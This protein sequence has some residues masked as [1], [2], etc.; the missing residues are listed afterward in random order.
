MNENDWDMG[1][2][3]LFTDTINNKNWLVSV[4]KSGY[5]YL[6]PQGNLCNSASG[7]CQ[8]FASGDS[9]NWPFL[10]AF[11]PCWNISGGASDCDKIGSL[12]FFGNNLYFWPTKERLT[13][14][15]MS[16]NSTTYTGAGSVYVFSANP[17][18]I[19]GCNG[20]GCPANCAGGGTCFTVEVIPGDTVTIGGQSATVVSVVNDAT[21]A[22]NTAL[23]PASGAS[24]TYS[25]YFVNP[26]RDFNPPGSSVDY[27][28]GSLVITANAGSNGIVWSLTTTGAY[29]SEVASLYAYNA[30][31]VITGNARNLQKLW[32]STDSTFALNA[33]ANNLPGATFA[34]PT[35]VNGA[36]YIPT[37]SITPSGG[38]TVSGVLVYCGTGAPACN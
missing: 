10:A 1:P 30:T 3:T 9:P 36:V 8:A 26:A 21:M 22:V 13:A 29:P 11:T 23:S 32:N 19:N 7:P 14:L 12:S 24:F 4:D 16:D 5:G 33:N 38:G 27:P 6:L 28:G 17:Y 18:V 37:Y 2:I 34:L 35:V 31:P 20:T 15:A 25:G